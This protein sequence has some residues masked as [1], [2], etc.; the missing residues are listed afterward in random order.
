MSAAAGDRVCSRGRHRDRARR[1]GVELGLVRDRERRADR[2][3]PAPSRGSVTGA[4]PDRPPGVARSSVTRVA[5]PFDPDVLASQEA[6]LEPWTTM[7]PRRPGLRMSPPVSR[8]CGPPRRLRSRLSSPS[9]STCELAPGHAKAGPRSNR[10]PCS[11]MNS[12][13]VVIALAA[14]AAVGWLLHG[15]RPAHPAPP[16]YPDGRT[17]PGRGSI[18]RQG[19]RT[20]VRGAPGVLRLRCGDPPAPMEDHGHRRH[21]LPCGRADRRACGVAGCSRR[22]ARLH[23]RHARALRAVPRLGRGRDAVPAACASRRRRARGGRAG[24]SRSA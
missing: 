13:A 10:V 15:R 7:W 16:W 20:S 19:V 6:G 17:R 22:P 24:A 1:Q 14:V 4:D 18:E 9:S 8:S 2:P 21:R 23:R 5:G 12:F 11:D 3:V